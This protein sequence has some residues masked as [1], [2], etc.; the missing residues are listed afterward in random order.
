[1]S[2]TAKRTPDHKVLTAQSSFTHDLELPGSQS[3]KETES[4][5]EFSFTRTVKAF[6]FQCRVKI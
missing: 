5:I 6:F 1:M 3:E 4:V 2:T